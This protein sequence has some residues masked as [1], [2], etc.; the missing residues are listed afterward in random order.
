MDYQEMRAME[1]SHCCAECLGPLVTIWDSDVGYY[2]LICGKDHHHRDFKRIGSVAQAVRRGEAD[3]LNGPGTQKSFEQVAKQRQSMP[4]NLVIKDLGTMAVLPDQAIK[5]LITWGDKVGLSAFLGH[6]CLYHGQP[7]ITVDGYY[8]LNNKLPHPYRIITRPLDETERTASLIGDGDHAWI[9][10]AYLKGDLPFATGLGIVYKDEIMAKSK[11]NPDQFRAPV[12]H[13]K[14]QR[15]A[16]KR[17]EWQLLHKI[18]PLE[19]TK[20]G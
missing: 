19:V 1:K 18:I 7:Y 8:Y 13:D 5:D 14:P 3:R 11:S 9:A 10:L 6:V 12:A 17:A 4:F 2:E 16:E 20:G 15:M